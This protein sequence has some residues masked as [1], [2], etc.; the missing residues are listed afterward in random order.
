[1]RWRAKRKSRPSDHIDKKW[2]WRVQC[3]LCG[4]FCQMV[5]DEYSYSGTIYNYECHNRKCNMSFQKYE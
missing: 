4:C 3:P 1:M 2:V 5:Q